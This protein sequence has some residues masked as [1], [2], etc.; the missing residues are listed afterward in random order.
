M[1]KILVNLLVKLAQEKSEVRRTD[2]LHMTIAV[3]WDVKTS[4]QTNKTF[5]IFS[6][7]YLKFSLYSCTSC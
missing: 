3:D 6:A 5:Y 7:C 1:H 2:R 4:N